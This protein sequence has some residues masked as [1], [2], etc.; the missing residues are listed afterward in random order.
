MQKVNFTVIC[1]YGTNNYTIKAD[2]AG[3]ERFNY[4]ASSLG[5]CMTHIYSITRTVR[6]E[7]KKAVFTFE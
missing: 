4:A 1:N 5:D 6:Q 3:Y 2:E 7:G